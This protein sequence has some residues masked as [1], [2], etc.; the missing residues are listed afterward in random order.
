MEEN[1]KPEAPVSLTENAR[2]WLAKLP[3]ESRPVLLVEQYP[4]L[5][6]RI[7]TLWRHPDELMEYLNDLLM[8]TR[9]RG[10]RQGFPMAVAMELASLKDYY[11]LNLHP[12]SKAYLWDPR[13]PKKP[14]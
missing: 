12:D 3:E 1:R 13:L 14:S 5:V 9:G 11:E 8:D 2:K 6:N 4:R 7:S 10:D